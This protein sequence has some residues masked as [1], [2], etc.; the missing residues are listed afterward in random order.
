VVFLFYG[1]GLIYKF[2]EIDNLELSGN[3]KQA[4]P[5]III[6]PRLDM[7]KSGIHL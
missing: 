5:E 1:K 6:K 2:L 4:N 7:I 3:M